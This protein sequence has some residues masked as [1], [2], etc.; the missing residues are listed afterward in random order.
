LRFSQL[1]QALDSQISYFEEH[2]R[3]KSWGSNYRF[4]FIRTKAKIRRKGV[5]QLDLFEPHDYAYEYK[6]IVTNKKVGARKVLRFHCGRGSQE[7]MIGEMKSHCAL[8][9]VPFRNKIP[10][11]LFT[12]AGIM[13]HNLNR[14]MQ[15]R[16]HPKQCGTTEK[17]SSLWKFKELNTIR[18]NILQ[19]A[20]RLTRPQGKLKLT[21][22]A[23]E[24]VKHE[25]LKYYDALVTAV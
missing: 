3:P 5:V 12:L 2:W 15:M 19:R 1:G 7:G 23:N 21:M 6:V 24:K 14:E 18:K 25:L 20:G 10:N 11:Q 22:N 17:R 8:D 9:Y 4:I 16:T 13:A